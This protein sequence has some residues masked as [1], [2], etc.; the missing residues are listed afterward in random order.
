[1]QAGRRRTQSAPAVSSSVGITHYAILIR[2]RTASASRKFAAEALA[3]AGLPVPKY[4]VASDDCK[5]GKPDPEPYLNGASALGKDIKTCVVVEDAPAGIK[6]GVAAGAI[7]IG[8]C[9]SHTRQ[10]LEGLGATHVVDT[11]ESLLVTWTDKG[12]MQL[13]VTS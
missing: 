8:V 12:R 11:L 2:K 9:T 10:Q 13:R 7:T 3:T 1:M 6:A 5:K 4:L